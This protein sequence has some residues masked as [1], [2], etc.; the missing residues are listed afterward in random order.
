MCAIR[1]CMCVASDKWLV[2][3]GSDAS[4]CITHLND[5]QVRV[6]ALRLNYYMHVASHH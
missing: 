3:G 5:L 6:C 4:V 2:W 1:V